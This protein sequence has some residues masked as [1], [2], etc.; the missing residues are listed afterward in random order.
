MTNTEVVTMLK[1]LSG[2]VL[3]VDSLHYGTLELMC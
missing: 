2:D 3:A 1:E